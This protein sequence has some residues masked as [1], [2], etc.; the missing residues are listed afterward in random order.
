MLFLI[1]ITNSVWSS[2]FLTICPYEGNACYIWLQ[3]W[4]AKPQSHDVQSVL[5]PQAKFSDSDSN[6]EV[7][8]SVLPNLVERGA[9]KILLEKLFKKIQEVKLE[10]NPRLIRVDEPMLECTGL[11]KLGLGFGMEKA[12]SGKVNRAKQY[13][14][15]PMLPRSPRST[16]PGL[17]AHRAMVWN[18]KQGNLKKGTEWPLWWFS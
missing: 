17:V 6:T 8:R 4:A 12:Y 9:G 3:Q 11:G 2:L 5:S 16:T 18:L 10:L 14:R 7:M 15:L 1:L 13:L